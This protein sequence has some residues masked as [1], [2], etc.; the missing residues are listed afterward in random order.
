MKLSGIHP[1][2]LLAFVLLLIILIASGRTL[3]KLNGTSDDCKKNEE[4]QSA[5]K[6]MVWTVA[7]SSTFIG[8]VVVLAVVLLFIGGK[9]DT[10]NEVSDD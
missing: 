2:L 3:S 5:H 7:L 1:Y 4:I 9:G 6:W 8:I 10:D